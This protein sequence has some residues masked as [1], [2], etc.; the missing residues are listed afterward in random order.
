MADDIQSQM[1]RWE[2][3]KQQ[4][5]VGEFKMQ[6]GIGEALRSRC[7]TF[8]TELK[9]MKEKAKDLDHLAGYGGLPSAQLLQGKFQ[10][11]AANGGSHD[12]NDSA[13]TRL[14]QN[15]DVVQLM[16]D[17]YAAAIGQLKETDQAAGSQMNANTEEVK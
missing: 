2:Q 6:E 11:K 13:V 3:L 14:Q 17:T 16:Q 5:V 8:L 12:T 15:I 7:E 9:D 1:R 10:N 4:A